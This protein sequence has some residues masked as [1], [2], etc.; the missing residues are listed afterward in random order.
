M[1]SSVQQ[2][3]VLDVDDTYQ[4]Q[5]KTEI[6]LHYDQLK[7][8]NPD[9]EP[10]IFD[11]M[12]DMQTVKTY[13]MIQSNIPT[14]LIR[15][16]ANN[17]MLLSN[18]KQSADQYQISMQFNSP[19]TMMLNDKYMQAAS[20]SMVNV[21]GFIYD[22]NKP[23]KFI[24]FGESYYQQFGDRN[25][26]SMGF[27]NVFQYPGSQTHSLQN[28]V[29]RSKHDPITVIFKN[30]E[31]AVDDINK[32]ID[33][34][35]QNTNHYITGNIAML[36]MMSDK[37]S[38][39]NI[40][41]NV[42]VFK[43]QIC[44]RFSDVFTFPLLKDKFPFLNNT[45][46]MTFIPDVIAHHLWPLY[47][48]IRILGPTHPKSTQML[49][50]I[51]SKMVV[52]HRQ[53]VIDNNKKLYQYKLSYIE[54]IAHKL[55]EKSEKKLTDEERSVVTTNYENYVNM[56]NQIKNN[57]CQHI[58]LLEN[59]LNNATLAGSPRFPTSH[60]DRLKELVPNKSDAEINT[61][62]LCHL[63]VLCP[64]YYSLFDYVGSEAGK[65]NILMNYVD[66]VNTHKYAYFCKIC[67]DLLVKNIETLSGKSRD[68]Y[69]TKSVSF[70]P[71]EQKIYNNITSIMRLYVK[72]SPNTDAKVIQRSIQ[73]II[74][75]HILDE[76]RRLL[77]IKTNTSLI[78]DM[79]IY[80]YIAV[81]TYAAIVKL[82]SYYPT[83]ISFNVPQFLKR[84]SKKGGDD[85]ANNDNSNNDV[86]TDKPS[87]KIN[88]KQLQQLLKISISLILISKR[89]AMN[90]II[91]MTDN[92]IKNLLIAAY[93]RI[94]NFGVKQMT[95]SQPYHIE[96][97]EDTPFYKYLTMKCEYK[98]IT[99]ALNH[100][101][102]EIIRME[103]PFSNVKLCSIAKH[104]IPVKND[105]FKFDNAKYDTYISD[106]FT[107]MMNY[108]IEKQY[109]EPIDELI[110]KQTDD[111]IKYA[112]LEAKLFMPKQLSKY[113][114]YETYFRPYDKYQYRKP[115]A[116]YN[117][118]KD[119]RRHKFNIY[120]YT[121]GGKK[122]EIV[123]KDIKSWIMDDV[124]NKI[125][126]Q[127][128]MVDKRCS[129]CKDIQSEVSKIIYGKSSDKISDDITTILQTNMDVISFYN[130]YQNKCSV[131]LMHLWDD[132]K[133]VHCK[134]TRTD[135]TSQN[136]DVY[137]KFKKKFQDD[138]QAGIKKYVNYSKRQLS[139][140][141][142]AERWI[143]KN[144]V[145]NK[146][147]NI[148]SA[149][150]IK[151][152]KIISKNHRLMSN[153]GLSSMYKYS[154]IKSGK[155]NPAHSGTFVEF[156]HGIIRLRLYINV[157]VVEYLRIK[158]GA[159]LKLR[160][161]PKQIYNSFGNINSAPNIDLTFYNSKL[162]KQSF[163]TN[164]QNLQVLRDIHRQLIL[165]LSTILVTL[166]EKTTPSNQKNMEIFAKYIMDNIFQME[167]YSSFPNKFKKAIVQSGASVYTEH[168]HEGVHVE[169]IDDINM[170]DFDPFGMNDADF[171]Q[172][173]VFT[174][175][176]ENT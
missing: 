34:H 30:A 129:I 130:Y 92:N 35:V 123:G 166:V 169:N 163:V 72:I 151:L 42:R 105:Y 18:R 75:P 37:R 138:L 89:S 17:I 55:F 97:I 94:T 100:S 95:I 174:D 36:K 71:T 125:F 141:T 65:F 76:E 143:A 8:S 91:S 13:G 119:G 44:P 54:Y 146:A 154:T 48:H 170:N 53:R 136:V 164:N 153:L 31:T 109:A 78:V 59:V 173:E 131:K 63:K 57:T 4:E 40:T 158:N 124:K 43:R 133:C 7:I 73:N 112:E 22:T 25:L 27:T 46:K 175:M 69:G 33:I 12:L 41:T 103:N 9:I 155:S 84:G 58:M 110:K 161:V 87:I 60:W 145:Q 168:N 147:L 116:Y 70:D 144:S 82:I 11:E 38:P 64:H 152:S 81:Y 83:L 10:H 79:T 114:A 104:N 108:V 149:A 20:H 77:Q 171:D 56:N 19:V 93:K 52:D 122:Y 61:C 68:G 137:N 142:A 126:V 50:D 80:V 128:K 85:I 115:H 98:N 62:N 1:A 39:Y 117:N 127:M 21:V 107:G 26:I 15:N 6:E 66:H 160:D 45:W 24:G 49:E 28:S 134:I 156:I 113:M 139:K 96:F 162:Y 120:I 135:M 118:C 23:K 74:T 157:I 111:G 165:T 86:V 99:D 148:D 3:V 172:A 102:T 88:V 5:T 32:A 2:I 106:S 132:V 121:H 47:K 159:S 67:G 29:F 167:Q 51:K 176:V 14:I 16:I 140:K 90:K 150:S 101:V